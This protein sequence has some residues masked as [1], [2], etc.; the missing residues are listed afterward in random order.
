[1][2]SYLSIQA[3]AFNMDSNDG[4]EPPEPEGDGDLPDDDEFYDGELPEW[5]PDDDDRSL[6]VHRDGNEFVINTSEL[7]QDDGDGEDLL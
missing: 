7:L 4:N 2:R 3:L 6:R 5:T 1:M